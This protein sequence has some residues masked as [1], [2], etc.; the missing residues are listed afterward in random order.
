[1][2]IVTTFFSNIN[3]P[4]AILS[5]CMFGFLGILGGIAS[6]L[7]GLFS[8][9]DKNKEALFGLASMFGA[10]EAKKQMSKAEWKRFQKMRS[11]Y[12]KEILGGKEFSGGVDPRLEASQG[13]WMRNIG[14]AN[15]Y[16]SPT[17]VQP[18]TQQN[19]GLRVLGKILGSKGQQRRM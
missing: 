3:N 10:G 11:T 4:L 19:A 2:G 8:K 18:S 12:F 1:M 6:L 14:M 9:G 15:P 16:G 17:N 13:E 5:C 7:G